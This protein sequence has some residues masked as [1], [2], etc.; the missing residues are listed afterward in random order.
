MEQQNINRVRA[1]NIPIAILIFSNNGDYVYKAYSPQEYYCRPDGSE[2]D[3]NDEQ[4]GQFMAS[5][6]NHISYNH[7][8]PIMNQTRY[9]RLLEI[10]TRHVDFPVDQRGNSIW[11]ITYIHPYCNYKPIHRQHPIFFDVNL[12][13]DYHNQHQQHQQIYKTEATHQII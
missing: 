9:G 11:F 6:Y 1:T 4:F 10:H 3:S 8:N 13:I 5:I 2:P 12:A 7:E